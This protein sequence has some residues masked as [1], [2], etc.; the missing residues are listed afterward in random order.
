MLPEHLLCKHLG[1]LGA[2]RCLSCPQALVCKWEV[3]EEAVTCEKLWCLAI[4]AVLMSSLQMVDLEFHIILF[5][6]A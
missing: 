2:A 5:C 3:G 1:S 4:T 6:F